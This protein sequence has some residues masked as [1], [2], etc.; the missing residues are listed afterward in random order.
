MDGDL[1]DEFQFAMMAA[2]AFWSTK[3]PVGFA[4]G[5]FYGMLADWASVK[6]RN[7]DWDPEYWGG[8]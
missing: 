2:E 5:A 1:Y 3:G 8:S 4:I 7:A 6:D